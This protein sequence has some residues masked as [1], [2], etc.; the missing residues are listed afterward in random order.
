MML[1]N[2]G[3]LVKL[4]VRLFMRVRLVPVG[5]RVKPV[6]NVPKKIGHT[7]N[8]R[9]KAFCDWRGVHPETPFALVAALAAGGAV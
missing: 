8:R 9:G 6:E 3:A 2:A 7:L 1:R 4:F 5:C